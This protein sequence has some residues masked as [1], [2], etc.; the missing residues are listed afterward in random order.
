V[1]SS[2]GFPVP[3]TLYQALNGSQVHAGPETWNVHVEGMV[4]SQRNWLI[5]LALLG[6]Q[7]HSLT[8]RTPHLAPS[9]A[10]LIIERVEQ[11]LGNPDRADQETLVVEVPADAS[12]DTLPQSRPAGS[13]PEAERSVVLIVDDVADHLRLYEMALADRYTVLCASNGQEG[14]EMACAET[15]DVVLLDIMMPD[16]DGWTVCERLRANASTAST[17]IIVMTASAAPDV[18]TRA[19]TLGAV[20]V[21][22]KPYVV[23]NLAHTIDSALNRST[24]TP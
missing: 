11:W 8:I 6:P 24:T 7:N 12:A 20:A 23:E 1:L 5:R 21:L 14:Y 15:P 22:R 18:L 19:R 17:P 4:C 9:T 2:P 13:S 3:S 16:I 10:R